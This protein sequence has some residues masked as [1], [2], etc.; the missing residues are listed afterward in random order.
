M[1]GAAAK[2]LKFETLRYTQGDKLLVSGGDYKGLQC[3]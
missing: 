1:A 3:F 2:H